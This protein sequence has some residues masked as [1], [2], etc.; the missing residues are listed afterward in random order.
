MRS[1]IIINILFL[2]LYSFAQTDTTDKEKV[3]EKIVFFAEKVAEF[4]G[5]QN[6]FAQYIS[7]NL[8]YPELAKE[9]N[10]QGKVY[11]QFD[12]DTAG[13]VVNAEVMAKRLIG[14]GA[15][16]DDYCLGKCALDVIANSPRWEP[17][18]QRG[19]KVK[20][21]MRIPISFKLQ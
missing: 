7:R 21:R 16:K 3:E 19:K 11:I 2:S 4:P 9:N 14:E 8:K 15:E 18:M 1:L 12:I 5:G 10:V 13:N 20:M 6:A 17:A